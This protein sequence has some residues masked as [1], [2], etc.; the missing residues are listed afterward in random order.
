MKIAAQ[1]SRGSTG[2]MDTA[3]G[4]VAGTTPG[5][6]Y[7]EVHGAGQPLF[8]GFPVM[9]SHAEIFGAASAPV[10]SAFLGALTDRYRV[11][12]ADYPNCGRSTSPPPAEMTIERVCADMLRV[13]DAADF[14]RFA[15]WGGTF[16]AVTGLNLAART[17]R[18]TALVSAGWP[19]LDA[20]YS[21]LLRGA[22]ASVANP[23]E[24]ARV[25]LRAPDQY[26]QWVTF[27]ES[28]VGWPEAD[29]VAG[30]RC[31]RL[32]AYGA[33]AE[34]S[35]SDIAL[36][37]AEIIRSTRRRLEGLGWRVIEIP[38]SGSAVI[39]DPGTLVPVVRSWLDGAQ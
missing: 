17:D 25:I 36:P 7:Y 31:P 22:R 26:A 19:P 2:G 11:L 13:A 4:L 18:L 20:P 33:D 30:I 29:A 21:Q 39:L 14:E 37:M 9:A 28:L 35:V 15:W 32:V 34:T 16:G 5:G 24:H 12:I 10:R 38:D 23:P 3:A 27:Y 6:I 8:L 1:D